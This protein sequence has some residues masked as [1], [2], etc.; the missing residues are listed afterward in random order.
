MFRKGKSAVKGVSKKSW[1]G[2]ETEARVEEKGLGWRIA[3]WEFTEK[4]NSHLLG[5]RG[6]RQ[7]SDQCSN[8]NRA[9]CVVSTTLETERSEE[10]PNGQ[11]VSINRAADR[12][13]QRSRAIIDEKRKAQG[14]ER[15]LA[16]HLDELE[17]SDFCDFDKPHKHA[18]QKRKTEFNEQCKEGGQLK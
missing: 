1:S 13:R 9:P 12:R 14:Q 10:K 15:I 6:R 11:I 18:Y 5:L 17:R 4:K 3:W 16:K 8:Q 2:T 7:Y